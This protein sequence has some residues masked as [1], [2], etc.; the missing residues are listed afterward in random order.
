ME[1]AKL[2]IKLTREGLSAI[3]DQIQRSKHL[4][5]LLDGSSHFTENCEWTF[6][7]V[8][9]RQAYYLHLP[10]DKIEILEFLFKVELEHPSCLGSEWSS[11]NRDRR[12]RDK[13]LKRILKAIQKF[14]KEDK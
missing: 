11:Y 1:N 12:L 10:I 5:L 13:M 8:N 4:S 2:T 14:N 6:D 7:E 9:N 3:S